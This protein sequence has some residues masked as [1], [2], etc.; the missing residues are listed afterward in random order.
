MN[1]SH[2]S[3]LSAQITEQKKV[4]TRAGRHRNKISHLSVLVFKEINCLYIFHGK[5]H[6][7]SEQGCV[8]P[9]A[10]ILMEE[11]PTGV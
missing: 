10:G 6:I 8:K 1:K 11:F 3:Q 9:C 7:P 5:V 2:F 4:Y